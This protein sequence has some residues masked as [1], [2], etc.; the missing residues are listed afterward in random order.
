MQEPKILFYL[1]VW[2]R[3]EVTELCFM[4][5]KRLMEYSG[6]SAF[7]VISEKSMIPLCK[8]Y[9]IDFFEHENRPLGLKKNAGLNELMKK[10]FD[11][12]IELGSDDLILNSVIDLYKPM[13]KS[14]EDFFGSNKI[15][16][17]DSTNGQ[18]RSYEA[19]EGQYGMGWG[20]GRCVSRKLLEKVGSKVKM[21]VHQTCFS[22]ITEDIWYENS[23]GWASEEQAKN[24]ERSGLVTIEDSKLTYKLWTDEAEKC[25]DNDSN[26]RI[27]AHGFKYKVLSTPE[28]L[29]A[30]I[31]SDENLW[32]FNPEI[33]EQGDLEKFISQLSAKEKELFFIN[34]KKLK[35]KRIEKAIA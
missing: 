25:L 7:A 23:I 8:K 2:K 19:L 18:C 9:G 13:M 5:L 14:G 4:G 33:G 6:A 35:A 29:M 20:L 11:Y 10:E 32:G 34:Q 12:L 3:L 16:F 24:L 28:P 30:D 31:K 27:M 17:I 21:K 15:L 22:T 1:A 26:A